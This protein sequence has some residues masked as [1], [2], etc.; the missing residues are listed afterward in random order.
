MGAMMPDPQQEEIKSLIRDTLADN[1]RVTVSSE[2]GYPWNDIEV[3]ILF[4]GKE[5]SSDTMSL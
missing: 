1:L 5:I 2:M 3:T 4:D